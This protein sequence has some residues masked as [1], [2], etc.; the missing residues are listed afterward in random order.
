MFPR[1]FA[2]ARLVYLTDESRSKEIMIIFI[3]DLKKY[4]LTASELNEGGVN[5]SRM[6]EIE[7][8]HL[9]RIS[10]TLTVVQTVG[11]PE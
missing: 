2:Y 4:G 6:P 1:D 3:D 9:E 10:G 5:A 11:R 7:Q 8:A